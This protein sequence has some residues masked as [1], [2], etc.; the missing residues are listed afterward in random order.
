MV[1][2]KMTSNATISSAPIGFFDSGIGGLSIWQATTKALPN[3]STIYLADTAN[4]PYGSKDDSFI[5][6]RSITNTEWLI[7]QGCKLVVI[8]C[9]TA[10][11]AAI[12]RLR[13]QFSIPFVGIEP[14]IKPAAKS[15]KTKIIGVLATAGTLRGRHFAETSK[16]LPQDIKIVVQEA[17]GWVEAVE[18]GETAPQ[19]QTLEL[20]NQYVE[21]L[22]KQGADTL[23]LG[24]THFPFLEE[25]IKKVAGANINLI[26]PA[27][28]VAKQ[29]KQVLLRN[30]L[31]APPNATATHSFESTGDKTMLKTIASKILK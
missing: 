29:V 12:A 13:A 19:G 3:E 30:N 10:T 17:L 18:R 11:A 4:C 1:I 7:E 23:V 22:I 20:V 16:A 25:A 28:A 2:D 26:N 14:A 24:C 9:N 6:Q 27:D 8:A 21:P 5:I 15:T 31:F